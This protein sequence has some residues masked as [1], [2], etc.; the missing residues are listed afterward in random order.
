MEVDVSLINNSVKT[1]F[2]QLTGYY[3]EEAEL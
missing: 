2:D 3:G 1:L